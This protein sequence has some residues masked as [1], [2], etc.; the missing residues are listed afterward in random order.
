MAIAKAYVA[1]LPEP[2]R[3][4]HTARYVEALSQRDAA[5]H[6]GL[7]RPKVRKLEDKLRRELQRLLE[8]GELRLGERADSIN[9][10][11]E[12]RQWTPKPKP[13]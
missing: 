4:V 11:N 9:D 13:S 3:A 1:N 5:K 2:I 10:S 8:E 12:A 6:L 7:S